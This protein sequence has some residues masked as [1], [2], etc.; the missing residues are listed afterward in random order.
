MPRRNIASALGPAGVVLEA[1]QLTIAAKRRAIPPGAMMVFFVGL[2]LFVLGSL[3]NV[4]GWTIH[5]R[6]VKGT[7]EF[8]GW[9]LEV[10]RKWF[11]V[12][13]GE[14]APGGAAGR[15]RRHPR[16]DRSRDH[17]RWPNCLDRLVR[18]HA[19]FDRHVRPAP[20]RSAA[21]AAFHA[22]IIKTRDKASPTGSEK[23]T[24]SSG[25]VCPVRDNEG[26]D[27][28]IAVLLRRG[29]RIRHL[30]LPFSLHKYLGATFPDCQVSRVET[31]AITVFRFRADHVQTH[32]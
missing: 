4:L 28:Q 20:V 14:R 13:T 23:T 26:G 11:D 32:E 9:L 18:A 29:R 1:M 21:A 24:A 3:L 31:A 8:M 6:S 30:S 22:Q 19:R 2:G 16:R 7:E 17:G 15:L 27:I 5:R 25:Q 10:V 12:L